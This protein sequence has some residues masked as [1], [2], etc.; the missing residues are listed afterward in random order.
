M[1]S[2]LE[3][4]QF[5]VFFLC[6]CQLRICS[7]KLRFNKH[8]EFKILQVADMHFADGKKTLCEDVLPQQMKTCS[9]LNTTAFIRRMI[10][11]EK[12]DL[13]V[14]T[15]IYVSWLVTFYTEFFIVSDY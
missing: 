14:F 9:D 1:V 2:K 3:F 11:A 8:G 6:L 12:P 4:L 13:I 5:V 7:G 15:G 10:I